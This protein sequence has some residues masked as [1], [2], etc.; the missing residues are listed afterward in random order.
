M[1]R[2]AGVFLLLAV[3]GGGQ[4]A[5]GD[6]GQG[7]GH[8]GA[9]VRREFVYQSADKL[10]SVTVA[11][12][13]NKWDTAANPLTPDAGGKTWRVT[14]DIPYGRNAYKFFVNGETWLADPQQ[15]AK[16]SDGNTVLIVLPPDY[17]HPA[18]SS[19]GAVTQSALHHDQ[20]LDWV[21]Y[22][23]GRLTVSL[24]ARPGDLAQVWLKT[25][26]RRYP[27]TL[28]SSDELYARYSASVP[29]DRKG[30]LTYLFVL[31]DG[32]TTQ[33]FG[34]AGLGAPG[35][36]RPFVL[37]ASE[38]QP[39]V[40]P[41]WVERSVIYQI[42]PD[43]FADGDKTNDPPN[44]QPWDSVP[45][46]GSRFGGDA[47]GVQ[48]HLAYLQ[49]L[50][51]SAV[52]FNP[53]F[54][55]PS[56]HRYDVDDY[57]AVDPQFGTNAEFVRLTRALQSQGIRTVMDFVFNHS[58]AGFAPFQDVVKNGPQSAYKDWYF[59]KSYPVHAQYP[60]NYETFGGYWGMPK[61]NMANPKT[62][63]YMLGIVAYWM[64]E[65]PLSGLRF[66][67]AD[68]ISPVFWRRL[69]PRLK[70]IDPQAW[71]VGETW[72]DASAWLG[73]DQWDASMN[74]PFLFANR[75]FFADSKTAPSEY[76]K[77]L[78]D[79]YHSHVP[80]V[81]RN[82]MN[83]LSS[84]DT[85]RFLTLCH[86]N[87]D[88]ARLAAAVQFTWPGVPSVY[89][90]EEIG[91]QGGADPDNR[92]GMAWNLAVPDNP[93]LRY[94]KRLIA[95]R[96][97]SPALQSGDPAILMTDDGAQTLAYARTLGDDMAI[98]AVNRSDKAQT[99]RIPL[100][101]S[102]ALRAARKIG[103]VDGLSGNRVSLGMARTLVVTLQPLRA[104]IFLPATKPLLALTAQ[105]DTGT[106][107]GADHA[108]V[109]TM[110]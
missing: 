92:R 84:H 102:G 64:K 1:L 71:I 56:N 35:Q 5:R 100:P 48:D 28:V 12:T 30:D 47:R 74:Y 22:D 2:L 36:A 49:Q 101:A 41:A 4:Q 21:N 27:M 29:W 78:M 54:R 99:M 96:H 9:T 75:D 98:V 67:V 63:D 24:R 97:A 82:M 104:A 108:R 37:K 13:F 89:Y 93:M 60:P 11:G 86:N 105:A 87:Q 43:R 77:H 65:V 109:S 110:P 46:G 16:D 40:V 33:E 19:D 20:T 44:V 91:M 62:S 55:S 6:T 85:P 31:A 14:L 68:A 3:G 18:S 50:G 80:Q 38:F 73:G 76:T 69:R 23:R 90:G 57:K 17:A 79:L 66:D 58:G 42:F 103:L 81:S 7:A 34:A 10:R 52:Y 95:L 53:I 45:T 32:P 88:L 59:I 39:F 83:L 107:L 72:G 106:A 70:A 61:L 26:G 51:I 25:G 15:S 94:Y 8:V